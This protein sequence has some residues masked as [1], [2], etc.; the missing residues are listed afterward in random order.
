MTPAGAWHRCRET[1]RAPR[2]PARPALRSTPAPP[3]RLA[4]SSAETGSSRSSSRG[5]A[6]CPPQ[7][8]PAAALRRRAPEQSTSH[9]V[10]SRLSRRSASTAASLRLGAVQP[11]ATS[12][13]RHH[14]QRP[15]PR[16]RVEKLRYIAEFT[17]T[18]AGPSPGRSASV[19]SICV[20]RRGVQHH[21]SG[22]RAGRCGSHTA[23]SDDLPAP[24]GPASATCSPAATS[25]STPCSERTTRPSM[26]CRVNDLRSPPGQTTPVRTAITSWP[27]RP[28]AGCRA[29][30]GRGRAGRSVRP[31]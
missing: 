18:D 29:G 7:G 2:H 3:R 22:I 12:G 30:A 24:L 16:R 21:R 28:A 31:R 1:L 19:S 23:A 27:R 9:S 20:A 13:R 8:S 26:L 11:A 25:R 4:G 14:L 15:G 17:A 6:P 5:G 10:S